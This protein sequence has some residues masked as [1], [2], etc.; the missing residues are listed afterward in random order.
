M[1]KKT[2]DI[3]KKILFERKG[4][5]LIKTV[6]EGKRDEVTLPKRILEAE[7]YLNGQVATEVNRRFALMLRVHL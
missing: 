5:V 7:M 2:F 1:T 4:A 6:V 3:N